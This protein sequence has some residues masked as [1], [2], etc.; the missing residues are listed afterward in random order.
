MVVAISTDT[1][2]TVNGVAGGGLTA[3]PTIT[4]GVLDGSNHEIGKK[5]AFT[6][7]YVANPTSLCRAYQRSSPA[8][9]TS[10]APDR[11]TLRNIGLFE[12]GNAV[13]TPYEHVINDNLLRMIYAEPLAFTR[14]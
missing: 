14:R 3:A 7:A 6:L 9:R 11:N 8:S 12:P 1:Q 5:F 2:V 4:H 13:A 10:H